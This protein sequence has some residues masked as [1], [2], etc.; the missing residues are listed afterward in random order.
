MS[1][2]PSVENGRIREGRKNK[3]HRKNKH[4]QPLFKKKTNKKRENPSKATARRI[5]AETYDAFREAVKGF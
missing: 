4:N 3:K 5:F 1:Y 2:L